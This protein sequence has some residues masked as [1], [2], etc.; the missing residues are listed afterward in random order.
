M[1]EKEKSGSRGCVGCPSYSSFPV[2]R[3]DFLAIGGA[4]IVAL[5]APRAAAAQ[6][7]TTPANAPPF[8]V[9]DIAPLADIGPDAEVG[10]TY[11][12]S[13]SPAVLL[14]LREKA[15]Q[16]VGPD[17][18]IVAFSVLCTH[19]GCPVGFRA[20]RGL[21][22]CPCHW[23]TFDPGKKGSVVI[24]QASEPLPQIRLRVTDGKVQAFGI[25]GLIYGRHT[26]IL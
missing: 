12:D 23:T 22:I 18:T 9:V 17:G 16:G 14:R 26:N 21:L 6:S 13:N 3:R 15:Q 1:T 20:E 2:A 4:G 24:G 8:P 25:D 11:P 7:A 10:F 5:A 19:K